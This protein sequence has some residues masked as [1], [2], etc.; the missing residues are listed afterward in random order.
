MAGTTHRCTDHKGRTYASKKEM[1][2]AYGVTRQ[3]YHDRMKKGMTMKD[4][5]ETPVPGKG[6]ISP[7][8]C[9][10]HNGTEYPSKTAM[11]N[12]YGCSLAA[13]NGRLKA[14][15]SL[16]DALTKGPSRQWSR[17]SDA[18]ADSERPIGPPKSTEDPVTDPPMLVFDHIGNEFESIDAML[19]RYRV[20]ADHFKRRIDRGD[21]LYEILEQYYTDWSGTI[22]RSIN[23][24]AVAF[25]IGTS[26]LCDD[27]RK[28]MIRTDVAAASACIKHWPGQKAGMYE[29]TRCV[30][31]PWF[32]CT[33]PDG[34]TERLHADRILE[35]KR[36][37]KETKRTVQKKRKYG[38]CM[39]H[40][41]TEHPTAKAACE[42]W[43]ILP[44]TFRYHRPLEKTDGDAIKA[45]CTA[46][47]PGKTA[48]PYRILKCVQFPWFLCSDE[49]QSSILLHADALRKLM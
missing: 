27:I 46:T 26:T 34:R 21:P 37:H 47:W 25:D 44:I 3:A 5:L 31:F 2:A 1:L 43:H 6:C 39:D 29:I 41:G 18:S 38:T 28:N 22:Y 48:G 42:A 23:D 16:K 9:R 17:R 36:L 11:A 35:L 45:A 14:G 24:M 10:D 49:A 30:G 32:E 7:K 20:H 40:N 13:L 19:R 12:A 4:A 15:M 8:I 33:A